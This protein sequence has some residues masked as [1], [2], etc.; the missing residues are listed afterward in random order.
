MVWKKLAELSS[1]KLRIEYARAGCKGEVSETHS[2]V[3]LTIHLVKVMRV[4]PFT[5]QYDLDVPIN[6]EAE[7]SNQE[8]V[9]TLKDVREDYFTIHFENNEETGEKKT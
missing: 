3:M 9:E 8:P 7:E 2:L 4:D 5:F 6:L 1:D